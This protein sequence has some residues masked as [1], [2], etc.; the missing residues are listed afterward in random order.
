M[1]T[2]LFFLLRHF[3]HCSKPFYDNQRSCSQLK[4]ELQPSR[5]D[6]LNWPSGVPLRNSSAHDGN[7]C[8]FITS[9]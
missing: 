5:E 2:C 9:A 4:M 3:P 6:P 8:V 7:E 1:G